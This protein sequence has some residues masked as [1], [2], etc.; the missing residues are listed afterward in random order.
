MFIPVWVLALAA[1][2]FLLAWWNIS[3]AIRG[4]AEL[5]NA[6]IKGTVYSSEDRTTIRIQELKK[7]I[8]ILKDMI[9]GMNEGGK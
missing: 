4:N 8:W 1:F 5:I 7:E 2:L 9:E 3:R 6:H